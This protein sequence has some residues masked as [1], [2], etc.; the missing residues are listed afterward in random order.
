[1]RNGKERKGRRKK[2]ERN[3]LDEEGMISGRRDKGENLREQ[4]RGV[5]GVLVKGK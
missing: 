1:M 4:E 5:W 2:R 3:V